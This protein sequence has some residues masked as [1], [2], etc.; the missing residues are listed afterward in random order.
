[1]CGAW[2][3]WGMECGEG[4]VSGNRSER[5]SWVYPS[6]NTGIE[7]SLM[8]QDWMS[9][10]VEGQVVRKGESHREKVEEQHEGWNEEEILRRKQKGNSKKGRKSGD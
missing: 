6:G 5:A 10:H 9:P 1:M 7:R 4:E 8:S 3:D 2:G